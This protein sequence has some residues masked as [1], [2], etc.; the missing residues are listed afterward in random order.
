MANLA[1]FKSLIALEV[2]NSGGLPCV[3][4]KQSTDI[5]Q[6]FS[7]IVSLDNRQEG[8][9][10]A[11]AAARYVDELCKAL[12][13]PANKEALDLFEQTCSAF[14]G[15][16]KT[17]WQSLIGIKEQAKEL[18][19]EME[20]RSQD[21]VS[22]DSY[23]STNAKFI[24]LS[25]DFPVFSWDGTKLMG[26]VNDVARDVNGLVVADSAEIP[27]NLD[28]RL[29]NI[30]I[31][32][33]EKYTAIVPVNLDEDG[34]TALID[35][36]K[37]LCPDLSAGAVADCVD[38]TLGIRMFSDVY[39]LL[40]NIAS[41][42]ATDLFSTIKVFDQF[43]CN[44]Y[45]VSDAIVSDQVHMT[46]E[47]MEQIRV[48]ATALINF[49]KVA[50]YYEAMQR[51]S[52]FKDSLLLQ[53]GLVNSDL[54]ESFEQ[55]GGNNSMIARHIRFMYNDEMDR[56]P[57]MGV[58]SEAIIKADTVATEKVEENIKAINGRI[59]LTKTN[60]RVTAFKAV[61]MEYLSKKIKNTNPSIGQLGL[62]NQINDVMNKVGLKIADT[63]RQYNVCLVEASLDLIIS[64]EYE[65]TFVSLLKNRLG[66]AYLA[67][68]DNA[69]DEVTDD[70]IRNA[71]VGVVADLICE[72]VAAKMIDVVPC[73]ERPASSTP[74]NPANPV[75]SPDEIKAE[76]G[77]G[78][79]QES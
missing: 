63:I 52:V 12:N 64:S 32:T 60:A 8:E 25:E 17:A 53:G 77:A 78:P 76:P 50:A 58:R 28:M 22:K 3:T 24:Q 79:A 20:K 68:A 15:K 55:A 29:F 69:Q 40:K 1:R 36:L 45:P 21:L 62:S 7:R 33:L 43:I 37:E 48:N 2:K 61:A 35:Q 16:I 65:G 27:T 74:D 56:I 71:E 51:T 72:F 26:T 46:N 9:S 54:K 67:L 47:A 59:N 23:V 39:G 10:D 31:A 18:G 70:K 66:A 73:Q 30:V 11:D 6:A 75:Q 49:C 42:Q 57:A 34:R 4:L 19:G 14:A 41:N 13:D 5:G 44:M 38:Y